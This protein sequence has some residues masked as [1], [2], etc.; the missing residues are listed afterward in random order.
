M[1]VLCVCATCGRHSLLERSLRL[2]LEQDYLGEHTLLIYNN[3]EV[4]QKL[5]PLELPDNK[6]VILINNNIDSITGAQYTSLGAIY[7]DVIKNVNPE[8]YEYM[9]HW[10]DD[11]L[12]LPSHIREGEKGLSWSHFRSDGIYVAYKPKYSFYR[13]KEGIVLTENTLEPSIFVE[14][15]E[16]KRYG[17]SLTTTEQHLQWVEPIKEAH[18]LFVDPVGI[19]T[20]IYNWGD[21]ELFTFKTSGDFH[22]PKNFNN[23]RTHSVDHG[24]QVITPWEKEQ[25][26]PYFNQVKDVQKN[27]NRKSIRFRN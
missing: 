25:V 24:D 18:S 15:Q 4:P 27:Q 10:D 23:Y 1:H 16:V 12:F 7:N 14:T 19:P 20:L 21:T 22:N 5:A 9:T 26:Q 8:Q 3:S 11:D 2:F 6:H 13:A 17:Y